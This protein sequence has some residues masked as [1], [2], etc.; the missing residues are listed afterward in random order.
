MGVK[1]KN[2]PVYYTLAQVR[3]N[4]LLSLGSFI[5]GIQESM[6]KAGYPDFSQKV[7]LAF[8]LGAAADQ[9][10]PQATSVQMDRYAFSNMEKSR[11][12]VL[13]QN[14]L[15]FQATEYETFEA[16]SQE[17]AKGIRI[18]HDAVRLDYTERIGLRY[19]DAVAPRQG[20][21]LANYLAPEVLGLGARLT[22]KPVAY[23]FSETVAPLQNAGK[24]VSR[25][26]IQNSVL[27]F[28]PDLQPD[29]LK[30]SDRFTSIN[31][32]HAI[33]DTDAAFESRQIFDLEKMRADLTSLH[34]EI[35]TAFRATVTDFAWKAWA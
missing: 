9:G 25:V 29:T 1:L 34:S 30:V 14:A 20:E 23:S 11:G 16:F 32:L 24:I 18:L 31:Q 21:S 2:A 33:I 8:K 19:L 5:P 3:H 7:E 4:A 6:R 10:A 17:L 22:G 15:S 12:F 13:Q 35:D 28:P 27:A 26:I